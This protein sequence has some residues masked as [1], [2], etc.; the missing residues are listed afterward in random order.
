MKKWTEE[1]IKFIEKNLMDKPTDVFKKFV[2]KFKSDR[3][4]KSFIYQFNKQFSKHEQDVEDYVKD[5]VKI[6]EEDLNVKKCD[7]SSGCK[8]KTKIKEIEK[9]FV[10]NKEEIC[11]I[12]D[13]IKDN[14]TKKIE[15][16]KIDI[17]VDMKDV[18]EEVLKNLT[19]L[20]NNFSE[21]LNKIEQSKIKP[22]VENFIDE[23]IVVAGVLKHNIKQDIIPEI[24]EKITNVVLNSEDVLNRIIEDGKT[25][26]TDVKTKVE[27]CDKLTKVKKDTISLVKNIKTK[28]QEIKEKDQNLDDNKYCENPLCNDKNLDD[29][30]LKFYRDFILTKKASGL[31][32]K[33]ILSYLHYNTNLDKNI[34]KYDIKK[35]IKKQKNSK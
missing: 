20:K 18:K 32:I 2:K 7:G 4:Y 13:N 31:K 29:T 11:K 17:D 1:E 24:K 28:I 30:K 15:D 9:D 8:I 3:S 23:T 27:S 25:V 6:T 12:V 26:V 10:K 34:T 33:D 16:S 21:L 5:S 35:F 22:K 14:I 19:I